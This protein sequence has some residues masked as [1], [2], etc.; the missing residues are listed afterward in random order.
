MAQPEE[1]IFIILTLAL[2]SAASYFKK[3]INVRGIFFADIAAGSIYVLAGMPGFAALSIFYVIGEAST[4]LV[5]KNK[6]QHERRGISNVIGNAGAGII[7]L[8]LGNVPAFFGSMSA[9]LADTVSSEIGMSSKE[10]PVMITTFKKVKK[11]TDGGVTLLG[12][13]AAL[14]AATIMGLLFYF[15]VNPSVK[16][17]AIIIAAGFLGSM[18]DSVLGATLESRKLLNNTQVNFLASASGAIIVFIAFK[19]FI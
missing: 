15:M 12:F 18:I 4:R 3:L 19:F 5:G 17:A 9:A 2:F 11:G 10:E 16:Q 1:I 6:E 13:A 14:L 8:L 7:A